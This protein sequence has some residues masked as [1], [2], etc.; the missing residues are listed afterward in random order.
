MLPCRIV[1]L[2]LSH[3]WHIFLEACCCRISK[4]E[5]PRGLWV[6]TQRQHWPL[7]LYSSCLAGGEGGQ[8]SGLHSARRWCS[9]QPTPFTQ[10]CHQSRVACTS[11]FTGMRSHNS[12]FTLVPCSCWSKIYESAWNRIGNRCILS[13]LFIS[14]FAVHWLRWFRA[15]G[16][17]QWVGLKRGTWQFLSTWGF[18]LM[19]PTRL[20]FF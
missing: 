7:P 2:L 11:S 4:S 14:H 9:R 17:C 8:Y 10:H 5:K 6:N 3:C 15:H 18:D 13:P 12:L 20:R 19:L 16:R 1:H